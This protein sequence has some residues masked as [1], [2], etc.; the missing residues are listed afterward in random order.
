MKKALL[1]ILLT[2][3]TRF[4]VAQVSF[5]LAPSIGYS[6]TSRNLFPSTYG[7]GTSASLSVRFGRLLP[8]FGGS[9]QYLESKSEFIK[10]QQV[11]YIFGGIRINLD[12]AKEKMYLGICALQ[13]H[14][15]I[16]PDDS[17]LP[18]EFRMPRKSHILNFGYECS[19]QYFFNKWL[20]CGLAYTRLCSR[21]FDQNN[22]QSLL[23]M[24]LIL[25]WKIDK[26]VAISNK[27]V[28]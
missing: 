12:S 5:E 13:S 11:R 22:Y 3:Y 4:I 10:S 6:L 21:S 16:T 20:G 9:L 2:W 14:T 26:S 23:K 17:T 18:T 25:R 7:Y 24:E 27:I 8:V 15:V 19:L 1:F 28:E